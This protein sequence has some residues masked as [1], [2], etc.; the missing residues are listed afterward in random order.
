MTT[1]HRFA[2]AALIAGSL[3]ACA[4]PAPERQPDSGDF[5]LRNDPCEAGARAAPMSAQASHGAGLDLVAAMSSVTDRARGS[6]GAALPAEPAAPASEARPWT[7]SFTAYLWLLDI[8]GDVKTPS[9]RTLPVS[10]NLHDAYRLVRDH[11]DP[12]LA[13]HLEGT[14]GDFTFFLDGNFLHFSGDG[15][16]SVTGPRGLVSADASVDWDLK[17]QQYEI[18]GTYLVAE[19]CANAER[20]GRVEVLGGARWNSF[21]VEG[22]LDIDGVR[23][24]RDFEAHFR[25]S[26]VDPFVG[27]RTRIPVCEAVDVSLRGDVGGGVGEGSQN[28]WNV[29]TGIDWKV[30]ESTSVFLGYRWFDFDR[31]SGSH[32]TS[33]QVEGP[34]AGVT[35]LF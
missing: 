32:D 8:D 1:P 27:A 25:S 14:N 6:D 21:S 2:V 28:C 3:S 17:I 9:G 7:W 5:A 15:G 12:S 26:W 10:V 31:R 29:V 34:A 20:H 16:T 33:L 4:S 35:I 19:F 11:I 30:G 18:G 22:D 13:G 23:V 24:S